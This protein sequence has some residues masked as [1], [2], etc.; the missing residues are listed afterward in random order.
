MTSSKTTFLIK[1]TDDKS[2]SKDQ[3]DFNKLSHQIETLRKQ[4]EK[5]EIEFENKL[6]IFNK[7]I[8]PAK[9]S[10]LDT[11]TK[12]LK[13]VHQTM[14][15]CKFSK[16]DLKLISEFSAY[17]FAEIAED[18]DIDDELKAIHDFYNKER[19]DDVMQTET[20]QILD[21]FRQQL[22]IMYGIDVDFSELEGRNFDEEATRIAQEK[23]EA[24]MQEKFGNNRDFNGNFAF[25]GEMNNE[26]PRK[27]TKAELKREELELEKE[28]LKTKNI[29]SVYL[30]LA[31]LLHPD[32][33][34]DEDKKTEKEEL[35][36]QVTKAYDNKDLI[37]LLKLEMQW[38][39]SA[40]KNIETLSGD[41]IKAFISLLREQVSELELE[42]YT[43]DKRE[44]Y[45]VFFEYRRL[46]IK[47]FELQ[48]ATDATIIEEETEMMEDSI[49][50]I[51]DFKSNK[52]DL[53]DVIEGYVM[54][55]NLENF[56]Y[57]MFHG[58]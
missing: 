22:K 7:K 33:E 45:Q 44:K 1:S 17:C 32:L 8:L 50:D 13:F 20:N 2:L 37:S 57:S 53:M 26:K 12:F 24:A 19:F 55:K 48:I 42:K 54:E 14:Q 43:I 41:K 58:F 27:K 9:T 3:I 16:K 4:I 25:Q 56:D 51:K 38:V 29:R 40:N 31:K 11:K 15:Q 36:K 5:K 21:R 28:E 49:F 18:R 10:N 6:E 35:M 34:T 23:I 52:T 39:N 30:S 46:G 47:Q